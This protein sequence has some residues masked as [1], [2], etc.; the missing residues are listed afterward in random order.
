MFSLSF[1]LGKIVEKVRRLECSRQFQEARN[2]FFGALRSRPDNIGLW[3]EWLQFLQRT[4]EP[5]ELLAEAKKAT[6]RFPNSHAISEI[7]LSAYLANSMYEDAY[8]IVN[9]LYAENVGYPINFDRMARIHRF[10]LGAFC[11][12]IEKE[13]KY[14]VEKIRRVAGELKKHF[15]FLKHLVASRGARLIYVIGNCQSWPLIRILNSNKSLTDRYV[16]VFYK[17]IHTLSEVEMYAVSEILDIFDVVVTQRVVNVDRYGPLVTADLQKRLGEKIITYPTCW[18]NAYFP[19]AL[20][21]S[22]IDCPQ[23]KYEHHSSSVIQSFVSGASIREASD[24]L[25]QLQISPKLIE[26]RLVANFVETYERDKSLDIKIGNF[27]ERNYQDSQLF[28]TFNHCSVSVIGF[29]ANAT[30]N[31][32]GEPELDLSSI[33]RFEGLN[34]VIW[35]VPI[36]VKN[37]LGLKFANENFVIDKTPVDISGFVSDSYSYYGRLSEDAVANFTKQANQS[38]TLAHSDE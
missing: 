21:S 27:L 8:V 18:F 23:F 29:V 5:I 37:A 7:A 35:P 31:Y 38:L 24:K 11:E 30:C 28:Y 25:M 16:S 1:D 17:T 36:Y 19:D 15:L 33:D 22:G 2:I 20:S 9:K 26:S 4:T 10:A 3:I 34:R 14:K 6:A 12:C 32:L 13:E